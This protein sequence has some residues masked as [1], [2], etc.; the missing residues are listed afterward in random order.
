M[1]E[2]IIIINYYFGDEN[3][4]YFIVIK[5]YTINISLIKA[6]EK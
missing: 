5:I 3:L 6:N 2:G 4:L 1:S